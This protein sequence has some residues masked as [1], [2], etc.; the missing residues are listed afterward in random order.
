MHADKGGWLSLNS[1][2]EDSIIRH[3][4]QRSQ[5]DDAVVL[6]HR[7]KGHSPNRV[8]FHRKVAQN[9]V[10]RS[11]NSRT[12]QRVSTSLH[13]S[14]VKVNSHL[15]ESADQGRRCVMRVILHGQGKGKVDPRTGHEGP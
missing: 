13:I 8:L 10:F 7:A 14:S 5:F 12:G 6:L 15:S 9:N 4:V 1:T 2:P 3:P 11:P